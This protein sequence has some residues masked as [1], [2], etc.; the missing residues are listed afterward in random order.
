[1]VRM[2]TIYSRVFGNIPYT[3]CAYPWQSEL[4][5]VRGLQLKPI[6]LTNVLHSFQDSPSSPT[7]S[8]LKKMSSSNRPNMATAIDTRVAVVWCETLDVI[9][10]LVLPLHS[11]GNQALHAFFEQNTWFHHCL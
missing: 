9:G 6:L 4:L 11:D 10:E 2:L 8:R 7:S 5:P 1:M 3:V